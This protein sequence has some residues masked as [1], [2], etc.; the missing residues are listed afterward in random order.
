MTLTGGLSFVKQDISV[1]LFTH[2][3]HLYKYWMQIRKLEFTLRSSVVSWTGP[4][5]PNEKKQMLIT[6]YL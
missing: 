5:A 2:D 3:N 6:A 4:D 1:W